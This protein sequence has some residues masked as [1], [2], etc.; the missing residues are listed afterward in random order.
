MSGESAFS[1]VANEVLQAAEQ[2]AT[3]MEEG[4]SVLMN[5]KLPDEVDD[6]T[7]TAKQESPDFDTDTIDDLSEE[8][9]QE[10]LQ[11]EMMENSPLG[12]IA[13]SVIGDIMKN[14][15]S[16]PSTPLE[17][18]HA[19]RS[20]ITWSEAFIQCLI[21]FQI[22]MFLLCMWVSRKDRGLTPRVGVMVLIAAIV[23][24]AEW[25]NSYGAKNWERLGI[26]QNY[27][28]KRGIFVGIM[29]CGPLLVYCV[30]MLF[31]YVREAGALLVQ[32]KKEELRRKKEKQN[33]KSKKSKKNKTNGST[34]KNN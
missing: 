14:Q 17:H 8:E 16:G 22:L 21:T 26:S 18:F 27:F 19:F 32:V 11:R 6:N 30:I 1:K 5:G 24:S 20:A 12:G 31:M 15:A 3:R 33:E 10:I 4:L 28:D 2:V 34:K 29:L 13:D 9:I 23:R 25:L 7:A